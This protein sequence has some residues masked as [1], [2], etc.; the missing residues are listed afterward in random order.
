MCLKHA[1]TAQP[2]MLC[3]KGTTTKL[4]STIHHSQTTTSESKHTTYPL[5]QPSSHFI[6]VTLLM[7]LE[8]KNKDNTTQHIESTATK[9]KSHKRKMSHTPQTHNQLQIIQKMQQCHTFY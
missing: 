1:V 7:H 6:K 4:A 5:F 9:K 3:L 8:T 2:I